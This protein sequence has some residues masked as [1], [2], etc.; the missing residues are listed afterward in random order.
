MNVKV[1]EEQYLPVEQKLKV[2][3]NRN[4]YYLNNSILCESTNVYS[5]CT[6]IKRIRATN[7]Q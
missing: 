3:C 7:N 4:L 6:Q 1:Y 2:A 5:K